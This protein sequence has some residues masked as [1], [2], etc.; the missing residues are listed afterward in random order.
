M[1]FGVWVGLLVLGSGGFGFWWFWV[2]G[3]GVR[4]CVRWVKLGRERI[5][6]ICLT[7]S[8]EFG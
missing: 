5:E 7:P 4:H 8:G 1:G 3:S 2:L 6:R